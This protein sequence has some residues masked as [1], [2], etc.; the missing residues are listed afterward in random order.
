MFD[1]GDKIIC[2]DDSIA[3][4]KL[5]LNDL[6]YSN[7]IKKDIPYIVRDILYNDNIVGGILLEEIHN[8]PVFI[9]LLGRVQEP[10]FATWRFRKQNSIELDQS[11]EENEM[12]NRKVEV[13]EHN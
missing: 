11:F 5:H 4:D 8:K 10:A 2:I 3:A 13:Y 7:W 9:K 6:I 12:L 1:K